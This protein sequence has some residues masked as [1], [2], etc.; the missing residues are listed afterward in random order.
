MA[1]LKPLFPI[2]GKN[3]SLRRK[4]PEQPV[5]GSSGIEFTVNKKEGH[6]RAP[7]FIPMRRI[8]SGQ[9]FLP[10]F[11]QC[12][13]GIFHFVQ[14]PGTA[15]IN[16]HLRL[17]S[18]LLMDLIIKHCQILFRN[19]ILLDKNQRIHNKNSAYIK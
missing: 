2:P 11:V 17:N 9:A 6:F 5:P 10:W 15:G 18:V 12:R 1:E 14:Y 4:N 13:Q 7:A 8:T 19:I 3:L 16:K